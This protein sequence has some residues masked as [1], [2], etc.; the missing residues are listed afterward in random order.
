MHA[1]V[2]QQKSQSHTGDDSGQAKAKDHIIPPTVVDQIHLW[3][4]ER[5]RYNA[6]LLFK[7]PHILSSRGKHR[8]RKNT[9][10]GTFL[11]SIT[12]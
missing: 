4:K 6:L 10:L 9:N 7:A 11:C 2:Q 3:E 1:H 5:N 8:A 12:L